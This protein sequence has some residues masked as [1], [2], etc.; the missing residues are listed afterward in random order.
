MPY[1]I[2]TAGEKKIPISENESL[3]TL[4]DKKDYEQVVEELDNTGHRMLVRLSLFHS[5]GS[6]R[7]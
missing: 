6:K 5:R 3:Y 7:L 4:L 1:F 2:K